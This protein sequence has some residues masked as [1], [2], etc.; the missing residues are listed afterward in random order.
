MKS[1]LKVLLAGAAL[2]QSLAASQVFAADEIQADGVYD[3]SGIYVGANAGG[4]W[5]PA[6]YSH[7]ET[8]GV[9][10]PVINREFF[11][12]DGSSFTGGFQVGA[13]KQFDNFVVGVE[14]FYTLLNAEDSARTNLNGIPR[15]RE[16]QLEDMWGATARVGYAFD[17]FLPYLKAGYASSELSYVNT[18]IADGVVV[19]RS[20]DW[21]GGFI[22]GAGVDYAIT[23]KWL[24]GADYSFT[25]F[26]VGAQQQTRD[27]VAVSAFNDQNDVKMHA[28]TL[29][30]NYKF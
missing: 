11:S 17:H 26:D 13:Q 7:A 22:I 23:D 27:G 10:G 15:I 29:R 30:L 12:T 20:S 4:A 19:G 24:L 18:R 28:V 9:G 25:K 21:V 16:T 6:S 5:T 2:L 14:G 8:A 1:R 3:W